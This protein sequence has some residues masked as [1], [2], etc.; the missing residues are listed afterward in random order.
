[1]TVDQGNYLPVRFAPFATE[2]VRRCHLSK[3]AKSR[4]EQMQQIL[5][6]GIGQKLP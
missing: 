6:N 4:R 2:L 5:H 1:M 3:R